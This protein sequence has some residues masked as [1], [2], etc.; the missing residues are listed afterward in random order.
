MFWAF[1]P[2]IIPPRAEP[3]LFLQKIEEYDLAKQFFGEIDRVH[4]FGV[5]VSFNLRVI[6]DNPVQFF[7]NA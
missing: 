4:A 1:S 6:F 5:K 2:I 7:F 3:A